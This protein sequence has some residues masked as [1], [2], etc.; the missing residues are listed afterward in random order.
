MNDDRI[1]PQPVTLTIVPSELAERDEDALAAANGRDLLLERINAVAVIAAVVAALAF[2]LG[3]LVG[4]AALDRAVPALGV[5]HDAARFGCALLAAS[6]GSSSDVLAATAR[7]QREV[8]EA[9][10]EAA[11]QRGADREEIDTLLRTIA[12]LSRLIEVR[13]LDVVRAA[14]NGPARIA[15]CS[16]LEVGR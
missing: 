9:Q 12:A 13:A 8:L 11:K 5:A 3:C 14:G 15:P 16:S 7:V 6:D 2:V 1:P 4:C 10:A